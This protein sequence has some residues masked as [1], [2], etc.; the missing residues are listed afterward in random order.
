[1]GGVRKGSKGRA[2][3]SN[4]TIERPVRIDKSDRTASNG[5][6]SPFESNKLSNGL[7]WHTKACSIRIVERDFR[8]GHRTPDISL[9][10]QYINMYNSSMERYLE[11]L[12]DKIQCRS[13][14]LV[15][16]MLLGLKEWWYCCDFI[17]SALY[18]HSISS[19]PCWM[20][21]VRQMIVSNT[22]KWFNGIVV[23][24]I[25]AVVVLV[26]LVASNCKTFKCKWLHSN[27]CIGSPYKELC[28]QVN[29]LMV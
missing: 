18:R 23:F 5:V 17:H 25:P 10:T 4:R 21:H 15:L 6:R 1:M 27:Q 20:Y 2:N 26:T 12:S 24:Y 7:E 8:T 16:D 3:R 11:E 9:T 22:K 14:G 19:T 13:F 28:S 29:R